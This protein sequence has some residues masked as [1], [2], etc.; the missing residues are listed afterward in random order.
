MSA[1]GGAAIYKDYKDAAEHMV[2]ISERIYP[3]PDR[4]KI[5]QEK[6]KKYILVSNALDTVWG[7]FEV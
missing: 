2:R 1:A 5:Y 3:D 7:Q 6:Y 4:V